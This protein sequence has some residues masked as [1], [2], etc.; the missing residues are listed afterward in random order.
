LNQNGQNL[1]CC[2]MMKPEESQSS[3][4]ASPVD[5][6]LESSS[7]HLTS[8]KYH[9]QS[10]DANERKNADKGLMK[11]WNGKHVKSASM[12]PVILD[13]T[14]TELKDGANK[15]GAAGM[16]TAVSPAAATWEI[17]RGGKRKKS[18]NKRRS[19]Q[20]ISSEGA[21]VDSALL[22]QAVCSY[23]PA[24]FSHS[25]RST[26]ELS[27]VEGDIVKPLCHV[28][29][30]GYLYA[31]VCGNKGL[32]PA[33]YLIPFN[34]AGN[35]IKE[36]GALVEG[37]EASMVVKNQPQRSQPHP[38]GKVFIHRVLSDFSI[39]LGW[40]LPKMDEFCFSNGVLLKGYSISLNDHEIGVVTSPLQSKHLVDSRD[41]P[42]QLDTEYL[43]FKVSSVSEK[44]VLSPSSSC[45]LEVGENFLASP[46]KSTKGAAIATQAEQPWTESEGEMM[47]HSHPHN[48]LTGRITSKLSTLMTSSLSSL[49]PKRKE[50]RPQQQQQQK[51]QQQRHRRPKPNRLP[52]PEFFIK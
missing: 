16:A 40:K 44:G 25:G 51:Q 43:C 42:K 45:L 33:A 20:T 32:V 26:E 1:A 8:F 13:E 29:E 19:T 28:D 24:L 2:F 50:Q 22:Y 30:S 47:G 48:P 31:E 10:I 23:N 34:K 15:A 14:T 5:S 37:L 36:D 35:E 11:G 6:K 18:K 38:P 17:P 52:S 27:L 46:P 21:Q 39:L 9:M 49:E 41:I 4:A 7:S 3:G 12:P